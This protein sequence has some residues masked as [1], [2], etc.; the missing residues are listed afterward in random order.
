[1]SGTEAVSKKRLWTGR[2]LTGLAAAFLVMDIAM[3]TLKPA[4]VVDAFA[5]L[6]YPLGLAIPIAVLELI[7]L[8][9]YLLRRTSILGAVLLTG[10]L[11]GAVA[12]HVRVGDP[13]F[14]AVF[15]VMFAAMAWGGLWLRENGLFKRMWIGG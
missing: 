13:L 15:P 3:H 6:G 10:Y 4:P 8:A 2:V 11:G 12:S 7:C 1:M 9:A 14:D 5:R